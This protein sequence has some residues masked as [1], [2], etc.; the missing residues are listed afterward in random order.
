MITDD[1]NDVA[2]SDDYSLTYSIY[3]VFDLKNYTLLYSIL[4]KQ[5][6][7]IKIRYYLSLSLSVSSNLTTLD[8]F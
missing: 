8:D 5:V 4:D 7:E 2:H 1:I 6:E 3:K